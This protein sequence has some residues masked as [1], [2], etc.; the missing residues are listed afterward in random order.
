MTESQEK[1][2]FEIEDSFVAPWGLAN[3]E[4]PMH[5]LW[6][7]DIDKVE[8]RFAEPVELVEGYNVKE[9]LGVYESVEEHEDGSD[10]RVLT[11]PSEAFTTPGYF[12]W[13]FTIPE[14]FEEAIVAQAVHVIGK[15]LSFQNFKLRVP[16]L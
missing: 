3:E 8:I 11:I 12:S 2:A 6:E 15:R 10:I 7:G 16:S 14:I 9:E 4:R 13:K 1:T 5:L